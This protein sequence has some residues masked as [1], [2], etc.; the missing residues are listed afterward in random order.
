[1]PKSRAAIRGYGRD[2]SISINHLQELLR[3]VSSSVP[4]YAKYRHALLGEFPIVTKSDVRAHYPRFFSNHVPPAIVDAILGQVAALESQGSPNAWMEDAGTFILEKSSGTTGPATWYPRSKREALVLSL[5]LVSARRA[6]VPSYRTA[7]LLNLD[8]FVGRIYHESA[9]PEEAF[10]RLIKN[11]VSAGR[12]L[13][14]GAASL[15]AMIARYV[16]KTGTSCKV[17]IIESRGEVLTRERYTLIKKAFQGEILNQYACREVWGIG[18]AVAPETAF[19]ICNGTI[20]EVIGPDGHVISAPGVIGSIAVTSLRLREFPVVRFATGDRGSWLVAGSGLARL[21][22]EENREAGMLE[23]SDGIRRGGKAL[24]CVLFEELRS[25]GEGA[26]NQDWKVEKLGSLL[27][28]WLHPS[29]M[30]YSRAIARRVNENRILFG[31]GSVEF[32]T[33]KGWRLGQKQS[34]FISNTV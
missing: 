23:G 3:H 30:R 14:Y 11:H 24:F 10:V 25:S 34:H 2:R 1:M 19:T 8:A 12:R 5:D 21:I 6:I 9:S 27:V 22:L 32:R 13:V 20:V 7:D 17:P 16:Q 4:Y 18:Y 29:E 33:W 15:L 26:I 28:I 31:A